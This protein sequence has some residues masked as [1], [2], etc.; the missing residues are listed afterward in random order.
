M[1]NVFNFCFEKNIFKK[2][3]LFF[4]RLKW[5]WQRATK[6][7]CD[8]D[9]SEIDGWFLSVIPDMLKDF[10]DLE[11]HGLPPSFI[12][13]YYNNHK[14]EYSLTLDEAI[15]GCF[16]NDKE[17]ERQYQEI[18]DKADEEYTNVLNR[19]IFLF[20]ESDPFKEDDNVDGETEK[21]TMSLEK[22]DEYTEKCKNEAFKLF[23][24]HFYGL[25]V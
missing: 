10:R 24:E 4:R 16:D 8:M 17:K 11:V 15:T 6:G 18:T 23:A 9:Y 3:R 22:R 19:M 14:D 12:V 21:I 1:S 7:Y 2:I 25:W 20:K 5:A 13:D